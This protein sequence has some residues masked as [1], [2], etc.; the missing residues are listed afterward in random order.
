MSLTIINR[1]N[2]HMCYVCGLVYDDYEPWGP[3][4]TASDFGYCACCGVQFGYQDIRLESAK[5]FREQWLAKGAIWSEPDQ[6]PPRWSLEEQL[7]NIP[8]EYR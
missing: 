5:K 3:E 2:T 6:K 4:G 7:K 1:A 8:E